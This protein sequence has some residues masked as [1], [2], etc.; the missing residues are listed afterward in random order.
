MT[1]NKR[2]IFKHMIIRKIN[3]IIENKYLNGI[4]KFES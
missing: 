2:Q 4:L 1:V 3:K